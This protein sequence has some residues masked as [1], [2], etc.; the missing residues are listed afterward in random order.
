MT[1]KRK[2]QIRAMADKGNAP[3]TIAE[4]FELPIDDVRTALAEPTP[5]PASAT[6]AKP[7][8]ARAK[9]KPTRTERAFAAKPESYEHRARRAECGPYA[10][11]VGE[12]TGVR[13]YGDCAVI[14][15]SDGREIGIL[16]GGSRRRID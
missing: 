16:G 15:H 5:T 14:P 10:Q 1:S 2:K 6:P 13:V 12:G 8:A 11:L 7:P 3:E 9:Q 4:I